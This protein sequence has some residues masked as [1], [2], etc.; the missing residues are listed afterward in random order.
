MFALVMLLAAAG[1]AVR[2]SQAT[3]SQIT[4]IV[5]AEAVRGIIVGLQRPGAPD[6]FDDGP[7]SEG[8]EGRE[9]S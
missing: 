6:K 2:L 4:I 1:F 9:R 8:T 7:G 5:F 3:F